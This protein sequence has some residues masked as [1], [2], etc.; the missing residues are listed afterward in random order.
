MMN[1]NQNRLPSFLSDVQTEFDQVMN[2]MF[3]KKVPSEKTHKPY[4]NIIET[5][6]GF[7]ITLDLPGTSIDDIAV[8]VN[9]GRLVVSG[10]RSFETSN[11]NETQH[12]IERWSGA[13]ER[14]F[15]FPED[16][17]FEKVNAELKSGVLSLHIPKSEKAK[18]R[19]IE[20]KAAE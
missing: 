1:T 5:E 15:V 4:G 14:S 20:I 8:E 2:Q 7:N 13:F 3:G 11:D 18:P 17:D 9:E 12:R 16:V 10:Q 6:Q 19:Q